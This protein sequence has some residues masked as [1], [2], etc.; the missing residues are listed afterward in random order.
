MTQAPSGRTRRKT[1]AGRDGVWLENDHCALFAQSAGAMTPLFAIKRDDAL[2][3]SQWVPHFRGAPGAEFDAGRAADSAYWGARLM[4]EAAGTFPCAPTFGSGE[5]LTPAD[6]PPHGHTAC[7][8]WQLQASG[9]LD[10]A[11]WA[12]WRLPA[13]APWPLSYRKWDLLGAQGAVHSLLLEV[14][15]DGAVSQPVNLAWHTT[16]GEPLLCEGGLL[17]CS[18]RKYAVPPTGSEFDTTGRLQRGAQFTSLAGAPL[19]NGGTVDLRRHTLYCDR[20]DMVCAQMP[21][22]DSAQPGWGAFINPRLKLGFLTLAPRAGLADLAPA[23]FCNFW[24]HQ[25]G[26]HFVP[27]ADDAGGPDRCRALGMEMAVGYFA[28]GLAA[29]L[30]TPE[31]LERPTYLMLAPGARVRFAV[32]N[33]L[34]TP[35]F[36]GELTALETSDRGLTIGNGGVS[37][38][39]D[40][41]IAL[42]ALNRL[43]ARSPQ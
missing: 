9:E 18:A 8:D 30:K 24:L 33:L 16:L 43:I 5:G 2:I 22:A 6:A 15:N 32:V 27:W 7:G 20:S 35:A 1:W 29:S 41:D 13:S 21:P 28:N 40:C 23:H 31:N 17:S 36:D 34:F 39:I 11:A 19:A 37:Q 38:H 25:G 14:R 10:G 12:A 26:R 42:S 3:N 4:F